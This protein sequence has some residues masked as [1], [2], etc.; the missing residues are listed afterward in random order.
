MLTFIIFMIFIPAAFAVFTGQPLFSKDLVFRIAASEMILFVLILLTA[1]GT[2]ALPRYLSM[3]LAS[4]ALGF[5]VSLLYA[6][7]KASDLAM[8]QLCVET[9]ATIMFLIVILKLRTKEAV[10]PE[11]RKSRIRSTVVAAFCAAALFV[12]LMGAD[13]VVPF[14]S[15]SHY[16]ID[17]GIELTGGRNIVNMIV[18][19][20]RGYDTLGEISVLAIAALAIYNLIQSR[21]SKNESQTAENQ[22]AEQEEQ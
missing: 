4:S 15:F 18:V 20:F 22:I 8:T 9:L 5:F 19:D 10:R 13:L 6:Y 12:M 7:L 3:I 1:W 14:E 2:A 21:F 11:S 16:F 17:K